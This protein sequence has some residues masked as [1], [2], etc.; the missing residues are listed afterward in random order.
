M[1]NKIALITGASGGIGQAIA[2]AFAKQGTHV[3]L[4][5][6]NAASINDLATLDC[7]PGDILLY[8]KD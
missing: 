4:V 2:H 7:Q 8:V 5:D 1:Q 3:V 6:L